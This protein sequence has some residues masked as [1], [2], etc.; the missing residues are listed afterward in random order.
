MSES[1]DPTIPKPCPRCGVSAATMTHTVGN[2]ISYRIRCPMG[3]MM[4]E[5]HHTYRHQAFTGRARRAAVE[6]W[7]GME[8]KR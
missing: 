5:V 4:T 7:N 2:H 3:C 6:E 8:A 1:A